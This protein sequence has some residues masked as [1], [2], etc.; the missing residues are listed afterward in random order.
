M[1]ETPDPDPRRREALSALK[2]AEARSRLFFETS[3]AGIYTCTPDCVFLECNDSFARILGYPSPQELLSIDGRHLYFSL[4]EHDALLAELRE[5]SSVRDREVRLRRRD[6]APVWVIANL[7][8]V[9]EEEIGITVI[10]GSIVDITDRKAAEE[11]LRRSEERFRILSQATNDAVWD[12]DILR[13]TIWW[14][15]GYRTLFGYRVEET[16]PGTESWTAHL[17]PDDRERVESGISALIDSG[18][19]SW[20]DEY[21][22][23]R[24][25]GSYARVFDRGYVIQDGSGKPVRMIGSMMDVTDRHRAADIQS[26]LYRIAEITSSSGDGDSFYAEIHRVIANLMYARNFFIALA[27]EPAREIRFPYF[28]DDFDP[29]P[30]PIPLGQGLTGRVLRTGSLLHLSGREIDELHASGALPSPGA[31]TFDWLGVPLR[32]GDRTFG[33]L[34]VQSYDETIRYTESEREILVFVSQHLATALERKKAAAALANSERQYRSLFENANDC[35]MIVDPE[36]QVI[37]KANPRACDLYGYPAG[38]LVGMSLSRFQRDVGRAEEEIRQVLREGTIHNL[39]AT[40]FARDGTAIEVLVNASVVEYE[41]RRAVLTI[42]R[43]VTET[44]KAER[45]IE[46]LAYEDALTGLANRVRLEDR[47]TVSLAHARRDRHALAVLFIDV[48]RFKLV[49]DSLGH[50]VGDVLLQKI[51]DRLREMIR[52][53]DTLARLGGDEFV[54]VLSTV[55]AA[56]SAGRVA[57]KIQEVFREPFAIAE[58]EL[59][60]TVSIGIAVFPED[61]DDVDSL[62]KSADAA[63][64]AA[65]QQ[66]R[67][68]YQFHSGLRARGDIERLDLGNRLHRAIDAKEFRVY[69]QPVVR[70]DSGELTGAEALVRW[71]RADNGL[72]LPGEFIPLAEDSGLIVPLGAEV[73]RESCRQ[74]AE[75]NRSGHPLSVSVNL[76]V[77]QLQR[78]DIV[79]TVR[80]ALEDSGLEPRRLG[81]EITESVAM[82]N[83]DVTLAALAELRRLGVGITMDDFGTGYSSLSYLKMLPVDTVKIDRSFVQGVATD[84]NDATIVRAAIALAH[85]LRLRVIAEGVE[86]AEQAEFLRRHQCDELQ[87][88]LFSP[89]VPAEEFGEWVVSHRVFSV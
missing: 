73:L 80:S 26:A 81:L 64:Y 66:G 62:V 22:F 9:P 7:S 21:R 74:A 5:K 58:R 78:R 84:P 23:R 46:R 28:V 57:R 85:E 47:L 31:R 75:W 27:D 49:N 10:K 63:M 43:D 65:K 48:D 37:L 25:D 76:S 86:S 82:Q 17:H 59:Y 79:A 1:R 15:E 19:Q 45:K 33:V 6:G 56:E 55:D 12:W 24:A 51:A 3:L 39:G 44:R 69:F 16:P 52:G 14:S 61:G 8:L 71:D 87:G 40:H 88:F 67:D 13:G 72:V 4:A 77:R 29:P 32:S 2:T 36:S 83:L 30:P 41:G 53:S 18:R 11:A 35:V 50:K 20:S 68:G 60:V 70:V 42:N 34:A 89:A 38:D 54:L